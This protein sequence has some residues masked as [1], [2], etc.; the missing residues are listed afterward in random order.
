MWSDIY[1]QRCVSV[2]KGMKAITTPVSI[3]VISTV[4]IEW[5]LQIDEQVCCD[6]TVL[7]PSW[8]Y[9]T[10]GLAAALKSHSVF[11]FCLLKQIEFSSKINLLDFTCVLPD[12]RWGIGTGSTRFDVSYN[13]LDACFHLTSRI[14]S[15]Y[16]TSHPRRCDAS[17][18]LI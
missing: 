18:A 13:S 4:E 14:F 11:T 8:S 15:A 6:V 17:N 10:L 9:L 3:K 5:T 7:K 2:P 16:M 1:S 12:Y